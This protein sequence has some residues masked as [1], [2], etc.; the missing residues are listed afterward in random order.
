MTRLLKQLA[1]AV[2]LIAGSY[3]ATPALADPNLSKVTDRSEFE[4]LVVGRDLSIFGIKLTVTPEGQIAG[5]AYGRTVTGAWRWKDGYFCRDLF[6]GERDLGPNCQEVRV[7]GKTV[8]FT[9]DRGKGRF[10]DLT[11]R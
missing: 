3:T 4:R 7:S 10:A 1:V 5:R 8:R 11:M 9:S 6:W 2:T